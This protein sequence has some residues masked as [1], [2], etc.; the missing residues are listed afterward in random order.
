[1]KD[2]LIWWHGL[3]LPAGQEAAQTEA[4]KKNKNS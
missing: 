4:T 1:M 3:D 2:I